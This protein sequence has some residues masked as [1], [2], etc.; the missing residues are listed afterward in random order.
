[1]GMELSIERVVAVTRARY[2]Q[3]STAQS[4]YRD[5]LA[6]VRGIAHDALCNAG[7]CMQTHPS[8]L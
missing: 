1:V 3:Y 5:D 7:A 8:D 4:S 2:L 6:K